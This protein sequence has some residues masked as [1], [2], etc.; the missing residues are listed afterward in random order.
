MPRASMQ[1]SLPTGYAGS[2]LEVR[3]TRKRFTQGSQRPQSFLISTG[4]LS[5]SVN[6]V[7]SV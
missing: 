7:N 4:P 3:E 6:P 1:Q 2:F 5:Y